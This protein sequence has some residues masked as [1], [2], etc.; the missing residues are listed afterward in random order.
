MLCLE[1]IA[2]W[3]GRLRMIHVIVCLLAFSPWPITLVTCSWIPIVLLGY[4]FY[5]KTAVWTDQCRHPCYRCFFVFS[6]ISNRHNSILIRQGI[7]PFTRFTQWLTELFSSSEP[8]CW[9]KD[10]SATEWSLSTCCRWIV[11]NI[12][13]C[14]CGRFLKTESP[15]L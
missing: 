10:I 3:N 14:R 1:V 9:N 11:V 8:G 2:C 5:Y 12:V 13:Y 6:C 7:N 4:G 15:S